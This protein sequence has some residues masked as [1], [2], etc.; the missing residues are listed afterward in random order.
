MQQFKKIQGISKKDFDEAKTF[1]EG[2][3]TLELEDNFQA[4]DN[5]NY[6]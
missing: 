2:N 1:I 5:L 6:L 4:A 3:F